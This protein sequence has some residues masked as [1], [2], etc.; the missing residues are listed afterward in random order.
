MN[1]TLRRAHAARDVGQELLPTLVGHAGSFEQRISVPLLPRNVF[2]RIHHTG[3]EAG[4]ISSDFRD[5]IFALFGRI[6]LIDFF[7]L[8]LPLANRSMRPFP[9]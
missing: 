7:H 6:N 4:A 5:S 1:F 2:E 3:E 9:S 8:F